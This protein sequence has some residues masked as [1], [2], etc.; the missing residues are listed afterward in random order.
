MRQL[1]AM[2]DDPEVAVQVAGALGWWLLLR[3][4]LAGQYGLLREVTGPGR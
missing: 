3:G 1:R 4:R 2:R